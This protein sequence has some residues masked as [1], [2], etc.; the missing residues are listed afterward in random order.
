MIQFRKISY[1]R[2][3]ILAI[4]ER[5]A[6]PD[7]VSHAY[8]VE[9]CGDHEDIYPSSSVGTASLRVRNFPVSVRAEVYR[10]EES[11]HL[12]YLRGKE[13]L[14]LLPTVRSIDEVASVRNRLVARCGT[15]IRCIG[16]KHRAPKR[17]KRLLTGIGANQ[18]FKN[19]STGA[20][21]MEEC[22]G[23]VWI[24]LLDFLCC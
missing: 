10:A 4:L 14:A 23:C 15:H 5:C 11:G 19:S 2:F 6:P 16:V 9:C 8:I 1:A 21:Q 12:V 24:I 7:D 13:H 22:Y 20:S 18:P 3:Y 17:R